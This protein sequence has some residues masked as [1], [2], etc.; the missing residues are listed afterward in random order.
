MTDYY[1]I[2]TE[3][4]ATGDTEA[5]EIAE[6][7]YVLVA[8]GKCRVTGEHRHASGTVQLTV[9]HH[10]PAGP[11]RPPGR[12]EHTPRRGS[13]VEAWLKTFRDRFDETGI[14]EGDL[15]WNVLDDL[16]DEYRLRA[17]VGAALDVPAERLGPSAPGE[18]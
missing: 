16:L 1:R 18:R 3:D 17:D 7:D 2:T 13:D 9:K 8:T 15:R 14:A 6:G 5:V 11:K 10:F 4:L 12:P